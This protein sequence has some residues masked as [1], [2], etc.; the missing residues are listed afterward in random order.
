MSA[1]R[2]EA[3][4][5]AVMA[6]AILVGG[7]SLVFAIAKFKSLAITILVVFAVFIV[8]AFRQNYRATR[9]GARL[10]ATRDAA[11]LASI[12][13][14]VFYIQWP[15]RWSIGATVVG[16]EIGILVEF[17]SK[18]VPVERGTGPQ[19]GIDTK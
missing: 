5:L 1:R 18:V 12:I 9:P 19:T 11:F 15:A 17:L 14:A 13:A 4:F 10:A 7:P 3:V 2:L 8:Y 6:L 16:L